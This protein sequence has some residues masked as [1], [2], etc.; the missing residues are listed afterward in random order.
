MRMLFVL[1][2]TIWALTHSGIAIA[3]SGI[4]A[5]QGPRVTGAPSATAEKAELRS[6]VASNCCADE[7]RVWHAALHC[8]AGCGVTLPGNLAAVPDIGRERRFAASLPLVS[9]NWAGVF[10]PPIR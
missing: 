5:H 6:A 9:G 3:A 1:L 7:V 8:P 2:V 4:A 10:R